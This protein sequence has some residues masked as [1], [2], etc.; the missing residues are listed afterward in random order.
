VIIIID[1]FRW[2]HTLR[3]LFISND[4]THIPIVDDEG[5][6]G[7]KKKQYTFQKRKQKICKSKGSISRIK[8]FLY[9]EYICNVSV[10]PCVSKNCCH[11]FPRE[12]SLLF[13]QEF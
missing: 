1:H 6:I 3:K 11:N 9:E 7:V 4:E 8:K 13:R 10:S 12:K 5:K 2:V